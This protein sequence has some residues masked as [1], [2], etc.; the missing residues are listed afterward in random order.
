MCRNLLMENEFAGRQAP[1]IVSRLSLSETPH[2]SPVRHSVIDEK[3]PL[4][5][6]AYIDLNPVVDGVAMVT[7]APIPRLRRVSSTSR[8]RA[9][10]AT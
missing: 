7:E 2:S 5:T 3:S 10:P 1:E 9:V 4:A 8:P 6:C